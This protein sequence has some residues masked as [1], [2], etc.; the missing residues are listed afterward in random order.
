MKIVD[1]KVLRGPNYWSNRKEK[2]IVMKLDLEEM[3]KLPSDKVEGFSERLEKMLPSLYEHHCSEGHEGGFF[4]RV[5]T[6][7]WMGHIAEHIALEIQTLAG[8]DCGFGRTRGTGK[9]GEYN[10]V[11]SYTQENAGIYAAK[12]AI[13]IVKS[14]I[15]G[16]AYQLEVDIH[17]LKEIREE[18]KLGPSTQSIVEEASKRGI[19]FMRLNSDSLVQLG[20]GVNQ[21]RIMATITSQTS[22]IGVDLAGN[23]EDTKYLLKRAGVPV[24]NGG[25]SVTEEEL[26]DELESIGYPCVVKPVDGNHGRGA[27]TNI[28]NKAEALAAFKLAKEHSERIIVEQF[29]QGH[30][31]RLLVINHRVVA[32]AKRT[33]AHVVGNGKN[34]IQ[35]LIDQVNADPR[36]GF[37][38]EKMLTEIM[39][40]EMT[41]YILTTKKLT[42]QSILPSEEVLFLK[43]TANLSTGGTATD[44][45]DTVHPYNLFMAERISRI[46]GLDICGI[47]IMAS[48]LEHSVIET[49]GSVLEVN[50][51][52]GFRMH[53]DPTIGLARNV[54]EPVIDMLYPPGQQVSIPIIAVTGTNGKTTTTRLIAHLMKSA[55]F[56]VGYTT[57]DGI[58]VQNRLLQ[59]GDC[60]GP[61]SAKFVLSDPTVNLAVLEIARG[62]IL[63]EGLG[64]SSC[65]IGIVTNITSDHLGLK[66]IQTVEQMAKV[67]AVVA[68]NV[69]P[70]GYAIL[71]ADDDLIFAMIE[72]ISSKIALF[73]LNEDNQRVYDHCKAGGI[74]AIYEN[75]YITINKGGWKIRVEK[76][77]N[78]PLTFSGKAIFMIQNVLPAALAAFLRNVQLEDIRL[79]L[80]TFT[81]SPAQTPGRMNLFQFNEFQVLLDY[82]HNPSGMEAIGKFLEKIEESPKIGVI[83]GTGDRRDEDI[84]EL[85]KVSAKVFDEII[86]RQDADLRGRTSKEILNLLIEGIHSIDASRVVSVVPD[87]M[88]AISKSIKEAKKGAFITIISDAI[89]E[90]IQ[91]IRTLK[92]QESDVVVLKSDIPNLKRMIL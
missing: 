88:D 74:A 33:P 66:G 2:L 80:Q 71:N 56:R 73:S 15:A 76:V 41:Q 26:L 37:G 3:E 77:L 86:I 7:T 5:K 16:K 17:T 29:V 65:D 54:A 53:L 30:D 8:M 13:R 81:P 61:K 35:E 64:F 42:L 20:Y 11:F 23:K 55:G 79:A 24:P 60:T 83:A 63:R 22:A 57:S 82:A 49:G 34:T 4:E 1:I 19:P 48:D 38:H 27:T 92:K 50:A 91:L 84:I 47:D 36:R 62:G 45:T 6:G 78:I 9:I 75:G 39:V 85:G 25:I 59:V 46:I 32:A 72:N 10:V 44:I 69:Y 12:A 18:D 68:E 31:F 51:A 70:E 52:P 58:Y 89:P 21:K 40:D 90:A 87:E 14:L 28:K 43:T 67:K